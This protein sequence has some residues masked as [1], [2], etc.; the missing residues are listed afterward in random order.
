MSAGNMT[1]ARMGFHL[2]EGQDLRLAGM[3]NGTTNNVLDYI[4][5]GVD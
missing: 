3:V 2:P 4:V 5:Y 1:L